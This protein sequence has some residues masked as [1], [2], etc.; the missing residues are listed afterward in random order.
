MASSS[1]NFFFLLFMEM[2]TMED[3][4][5]L[6]KEVKKLTSKV[7]S[8]KRRRELKLMNMEYRANKDEV[9]MLFKKIM[10]S[11]KNE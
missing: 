7:S 11:V 9:D 5:E 8:K 3:L 4:T 6:R 10:E 1:F 2:I